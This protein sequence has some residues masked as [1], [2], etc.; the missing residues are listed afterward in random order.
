LIHLAANSRASPACRKQSAY[1]QRVRDKRMYSVQT[2]AISDIAM[3]RI[4]EPHDTA[5]GSVRGFL[6]DSSPRRHA[7][8]KGL[9][10]F[11]S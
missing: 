1:Q 5:G 10:S 3:L 2:D 4:W 6:T 8:R 7:S 11:H 9:S